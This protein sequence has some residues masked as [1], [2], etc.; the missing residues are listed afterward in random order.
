MKLVIVNIDSIRIGH[1]LPFS[2]RDETGVLLASRGSV[3]QHREELQAIVGRRSQLYVDLDESQAHLRAYQSKLLQMVRQDKSLGDIAD[4]G[5][6]PNDLEPQ[7]DAPDKGVADWMHL[8]AQAHAMLLDTNPESF[9]LRLGKL[10][11]KLTR[12][13]HENPD[14]TLF[15]LI[16]LATSDVHFHS[17]TQAML[18]AA[19]C[20][21][22]AYQVLNWPPELEVTLCR[23][24]LTMTIG[25]TELQDLLARQKETPRPEQQLKL[26]Q[27]EGASAGLLTQLGVSDLGWLEAVMHHRDKTPGRLAERSE[28]LR[29][30]R[31]IQ[32]ANAFTAQLAPRASQL[33]A[34]TTSAMQ[35]CYLDENGQPDEAGAA[36]IKAVGIYSPGTFVRL[37]T[38][39]VAVVIKRGPNT[40]TPIVAVL[41]N[42]NGMPN[43]EM[44]VRNTSKREFKILAAVSPRA[45]KFKLNLERILR[46]I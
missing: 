25:L 17:A 13:I 3:V 29:M 8:Q 20:S 1:P 36:L 26:A 43:A 23:A 30:A 7:Q 21:L 45:V 40:S 9:A 33:T 37:I 38:E 2:L 24:A 19:M 35:A 34:V 5:I 18:T 42:R 10:Q 6:S 22:A 14:A 44:S 46:L 31:L 41:L 27:L 32:R 39:E 16:H 12:E 11:A 28:G 4:T 15:A